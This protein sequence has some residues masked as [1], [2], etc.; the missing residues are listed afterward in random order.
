MKGWNKNNCVCLLIS[1][2]SCNSFSSFN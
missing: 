2:Y 1:F